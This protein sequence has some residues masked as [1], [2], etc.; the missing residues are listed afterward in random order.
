MIIIFFQF[1]HLAETIK[2]K[3]AEKVKRERNLY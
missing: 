2:T 3:M 1:L